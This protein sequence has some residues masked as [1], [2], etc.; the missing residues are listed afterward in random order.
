MESFD[1]KV[2]NAHAALHPDAPTAAHSSSVP[3]EAQRLE[4]NRG[5]VDLRE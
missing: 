4:L 5:G 3:L 2:L 1:Q